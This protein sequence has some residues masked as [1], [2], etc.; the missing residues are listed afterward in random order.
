MSDFIYE[1]SENTILVGIQPNSNSSIVIPSTVKRINDFESGDSLLMNC[2]N[3]VLEISFAIN[4]DISYIGNYSFSKCSGLKKADLSNCLN[5]VNISYCLFRNSQLETIILPMDGKIQTLYSG[6]FAHTKITEIYIP[7]SV[8]VIDGYTQIEEGVFQNCR[9]L[10]EIHIN[11]TSNLRKIGYALGQHTIITT[12]FI[13]KNVT[14]ITF[15]AFSIM[16]KLENFEV[17]SEN[18]FFEVNDS[19][20]YFISDD[21]I[22]LHTCPPNK[23][24]PIVFPNEQFYLGQEVFRTYQQKVELKLPKVIKVIPHNA[25]FSSLFTSIILPPYLE[26]ISSAAFLSAAITSITIPETVTF[27]NESAFR[28]S[29]IQNVIF[30][31]NEQ[32]IE[33]GDRCFYNCPDLISVQLPHSGVVFLSDNNFAYC[34]KLKD[35]NFNV[36]ISSLPIGISPNITFNLLINSSSSSS[37]QPNYCGILKNIHLEENF[38]SLQSARTCGQRFHSTSLRYAIFILFLIK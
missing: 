35:I 23:Q 25:F 38:C 6:C 31:S 8:E 9:S 32:N 4:S 7:D 1:D 10:S 18:E 17:D 30:T 34:P 5:L 37:K 20:L 27:I 33:I 28:G 3:D 14:T 21:I 15:G 29:S 19:I 2:S 26:T 13:P 12:F 36:Q 11:S 24:T 16:L 22:I